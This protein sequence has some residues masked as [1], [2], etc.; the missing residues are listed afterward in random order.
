[1]K[2]L[3]IRELRSESVLDKDVFVQ[4]N[5]VMI[6]KS[7]M[8]LTNIWLNASVILRVSWFAHACAV[9]ARARIGDIQIGR[10]LARAGPD[11]DDIWPPGPVRDLIEDAESRNLESGLHSGRIDQWGVFTKSLSDGEGPEWELATATEIELGAK[12]T[13]AEDRRAPDHSC[14]ASEGRPISQPRE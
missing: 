5:R 14:G 1:L 3:I 6:F 11:V 12:R 9:T 2:Q 7:E 13:M 8:V 4:K 10:V